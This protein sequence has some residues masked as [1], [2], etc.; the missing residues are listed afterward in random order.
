MKRKIK[1]IVWAFFLIAILY[2]GLRVYK[3]YK[4]KRYFSIEKAGNQ[5]ILPAGEKIIQEFIFDFE[6]PEALL[7]PE[8]LSTEIS[9]SGKTS[10]CQKG[11]DSYSVTFSKAVKDVPYASSTDVR[12]QVWLYAE[13]K[14]IETSI[15]FSVEDV[16]AKQT[17]FWDGLQIKENNFPVKT[18]TM[19]EGVF[20]LPKEKIKG[21][22]VIKIYLWNTC[23]TKFYADD[24]NVLFTVS[25]AKTFILN[26]MEAIDYLPTE[27]PYSGIRSSKLVGKDQYCP[28]I[29][30]FLG[31]FDLKDKKYFDIGAWIWSKDKDMY[32]TYILEIHDTSKQEIV[33]W[34]RVDI[35]SSDFKTGEWVRIHS[36]FPAKEEFLKPEHKIK[37]YIWNRNENTVYIDDLF[38]RLRSEGNSRSGSSFI[39]DLVAAIPKKTESGFVYY[40]KPLEIKEN[41]P[42]FNI[43]WLEKIIVKGTSGSSLVTEKGKPGTDF[44]KA[45]FIIAGNFIEAADERDK[46]CVL[47]NNK[48]ELYKYLSS[49]TKF[50]SVPIANNLLSSHNI[51][52]VLLVK[53][54]DIDGDKADELFI[55]TNDA[56]YL[57]KIHDNKQVS[58]L[59]KCEINKEGFDKNIKIISENFSDNKKD[60]LLLIQPDGA[61]RMLSFDKAKWTELFKGEVKEWDS[62]NSIINFIEKKQQILCVKEDQ[63]SKKCEYV[64]HSF[65]KQGTFL[66][67]FRNNRGKGLL[68]G[69]DTLKP[70]DLF[71]SFTSRNSTSLLRLNRDWRFDLKEIVLNE[72]GF[73]IKNTLD[74]TA[75]LADE[76]PK[77]YESSMIVPGNYFKPHEPALMI[78]SSN[79]KKELLPDVLQFFK[80]E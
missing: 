5:L 52:K 46:I 28:G 41:I 76:N 21:E 48:L 61:W 10:S 37:I 67:V 7:N 78:I 71:I 57:L 29:N 54:I 11:K 31:Y 44:S 24:L 56:Y 9:R 19:R 63:V 18:W 32:A 6:N 16:D 15:V 68:N 33:S 79:K 77:F 60:Q 3:Y 36:A 73:I 69:L 34:N 75:Y 14:E 25:D 30:T 26:D 39:H 58:V 8:A 66:S 72:K 1:Y 40:N 43:K 22:H 45:D 17:L 12:I 70:S 27:R 47:S 62:K 59:W 65:S 53:K 74:F 38:I 23:S 42:P 55:K 49:D 4:W 64:L 2:A 13:S 51:H 80:A 20:T 50:V 35:K